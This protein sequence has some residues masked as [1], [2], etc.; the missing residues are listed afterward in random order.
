MASSLNLNHL[1]LLQMAIRLEHQCEAV[2]HQTVSVHEAFD[3]KTIW[4]GDVEV[5]HLNGH[6]EAKKCF[7]WW[8]DEKDKGGRFVTVLEKQL[9]NTPEMA[10]KS[11][12]FFEAQPAPPFDIDSPS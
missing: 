2:H 4:K 1:K 11:A 6:A 7:A 12:I 5:F 3:G 8:R 9:I 10:V